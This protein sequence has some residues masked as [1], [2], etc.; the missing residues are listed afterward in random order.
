MCIQL[1]PL[2][3][4]IF[5]ICVSHRRIDYETIAKLANTS[6]STARLTA[7]SLVT[8]GMLT[9]DVSGAYQD[10][11]RFYTDNN[12]P[13]RQCL[14]EKTS[15]YQNEVDDTKREV[16]LSAIV[17]FSKTRRNIIKKNDIDM[18]VERRHFLMNL[19]TNNPKRA[20][21][22]IS[23]NDFLIKTYARYLDAK[24]K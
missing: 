17:R 9:C 16:L 7:K 15:E 22:Y 2:D 13:L 4:K 24:T 1:K 19:L 20:G 21:E 3:Q 5:N 12:K 11:I 10:R 18:A 14:D 8:I 6:Y 23:D